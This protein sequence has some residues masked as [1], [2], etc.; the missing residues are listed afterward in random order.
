MMCSKWDLLHVRE[1]Q[2]KKNQKITK[3]KNNNLI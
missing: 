3:P 2:E 1:E